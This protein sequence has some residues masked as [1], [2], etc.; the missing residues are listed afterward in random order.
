MIAVRAAALLAGFFLLLASAL[1]TAS[2]RAM[3]SLRNCAMPDIT[4]FQGSEL[5]E[6]TG[7][8]SLAIRLKNRGRSSCI[9]YGYPTIEFR[10]RAG[11][12]P[13]K[14]RHGGDQVVT[15]RRPRR[16][17]VRPGR[18]AYVVL[19]KYRCDLG[20]RRAARTLRLG[21]SSH[22]SQRATTAVRPRGWIQYCGRGD[23]GSTVSVS[24]FEPSVRDAVRG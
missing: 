11:R 3:Q 7:Q 13:F 5:S 12:I 9:L 16:V 8:H 6:P 15:S 17:V 4:V 21:L 19:N 1:T 14:I 23:P 24:P 18:S 22:T 20:N 10:D 2:T